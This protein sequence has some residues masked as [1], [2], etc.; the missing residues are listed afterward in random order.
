MLGLQNLDLL[1]G[2]SVEEVEVAQVLTL[3]EIME[4]VVTAVVVMEPSLQEVGKQEL[5]TVDL[6]AEAEVVAVVMLI[7]EVLGDLVL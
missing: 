3:Q 2:G 5:P 7:Q 4:L 1:E 6:E